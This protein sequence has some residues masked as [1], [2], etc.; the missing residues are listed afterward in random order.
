MP[1]CGGTVSGFLK[2]MGGNPNSLA[3]PCQDQEE[4]EE[5]ERR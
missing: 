1:G 4:E 5:E 3:F 2:N